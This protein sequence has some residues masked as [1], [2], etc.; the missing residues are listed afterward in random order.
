MA[1]LEGMR[2]PAELALLSKQK[3]TNGSQ[4]VFDASQFK[5]AVGQDVPASTI[6]KLQKEFGVDMSGGKEHA[7]AQ[8][9]ECAPVV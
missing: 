7:A 3:M 4:H 9:L 2:D 1:S 6:E 5:L 8:A